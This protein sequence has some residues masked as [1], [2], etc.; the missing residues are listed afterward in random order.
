VVLPPSEG[1]IAGTVAPPPSEGSTAGTVKEMLP[2]ALRNLDR[3]EGSPP[4]AI[5]KTKQKINLK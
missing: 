3:T 4:S 2:A 5:T 1:S